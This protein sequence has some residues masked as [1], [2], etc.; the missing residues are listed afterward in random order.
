MSGHLGEAADDDQP[1]GARQHE[2][3]AAGAGPDVSATHEPSPPEQSSATDSAPV[4]GTFESNTGWA[5]RA[6][7]FREYAKSHPVG[8]LVWRVVVAVVG[9]ALL[10]AGGAMLV[11]PG[12]GWAAIALGLVVLASEFVWFEKPLRPVQR[13]LAKAGEKVGSPRRRRLLVVLMVVLTIGSALF[14]EF[15]LHPRGLLPWS[16]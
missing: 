16:K 7:V 5:Q 9:A 14:Y 1:N 12:P 3:T 11:L 15:Y 6:R 4:S 8:A 13:L 2:D 10:V